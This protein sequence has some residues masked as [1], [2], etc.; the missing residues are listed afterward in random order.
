MRPV[1]EAIVG[2]RPDAIKFRTF[3]TKSL[4]TAEM[5]KAAYQKANTGA[6]ELVG[7]AK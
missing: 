3:R 7:C 6:T 1:R 4:I 5:P 2:A